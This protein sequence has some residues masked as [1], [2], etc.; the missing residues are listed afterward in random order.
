M[1]DI[2][3]LT[4]K[5]FMEWQARWQSAFARELF[6]QRGK[7]RLHGKDYHAF[8]SRFMRHFLSGAAAEV[9]YDAVQADALIFLFQDQKKEWGERWELEQGQK[10]SIAELKQIAQTAD[11]L[12]FA[13][14]L[15][16]TAF[17]HHEDQIP[18]LFTREEWVAFE[19]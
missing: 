6:A 15:T 4:R 2:R 18:T 16:W 11:F 14:D 3:T 12:V 8:D 13:P 7:W 17:F 10:P 5:E 9:E 19:T 1:T